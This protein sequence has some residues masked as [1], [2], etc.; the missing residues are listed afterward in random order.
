MKDYLKKI[1]QINGKL[2]EADAILVGIG[3]GLS[4]AS[5]MLYFGERF[6]THFSDFQEKYGISDMYSGGF[7]PFKSREE[8]WAWW[9]R[10]IVLNRYDA[11]AGQPYLDLFKMLKDKNYFI[12]STNV[13][14]QVQKAGFDK[15]RL[16]YTQGDY[17]LMQCSV[18]CHQ[19]NYSNRELVYA[20]VE[21][22][23]NMAVPTD[24]VPTCPKC[25][26]LMTNNL[27]IDQRFVQDEGWHAAKSA[28][29]TFLT[30][31]VDKNIVFLELGVGMNTP[32]IIKYPFLQMTL[33][34]PKATFIT[35]NQEEFRYPDEVLS[36]LI[37]VTGDM[38]LHLHR[39]A[40]SEP[41]SS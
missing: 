22:Q 2:E 12:L 35:F 7:Y 26:A 6:E 36:Q 37:A 34:N 14:H 39:L 15:N 21:Q 24:L 11:P 5:G 27:R 40:E 29:E 23:T 18:P 38:A 41:S 3:A 19:K 32:A 33:A 25:G 20:M 31:F 8:F 30:E 1:Q 28:Y 13:D 17:G 4:A 9:S 16:F 10:H